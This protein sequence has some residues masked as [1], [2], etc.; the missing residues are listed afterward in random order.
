MQ[1][2]A[3]LAH[4]VL[5]RQP[6]PALSAR[7]LHRL[8]SGE[9]GGPPPPAELLLHQLRRRTDLFRVLDPWRGPWEGL[10]PTARDGS[11]GPWTLAGLEEGGGVW[12]VPADGSGAL[13]EEP[14]PAAR[15]LRASLVAVGRRVDDGSVTALTRWMGMV[16]EAR[17]VRRWIF[18]R[19][20]A[21]VEAV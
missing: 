6:T 11:D 14:D 9:I 4:R 5:A 8:L 17:R 19:R 13:D 16:G 21:E 18:H 20:S 2:V 7:E 10:A 3:E 15:T 12:V 1:P